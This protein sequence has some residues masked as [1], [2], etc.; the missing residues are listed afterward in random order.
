MRPRGSV[1]GNL[2]PPGSTF[3]RGIRS[4]RV[5]DAEEPLQLPS[6]A[7][8]TAHSKDDSDDDGE[9]QRRF[10]RAANRAGGGANPAVRGARMDDGS[11]LDPAYA[12]MVRANPLL[13]AD[14]EFAALHPEQIFG[15]YTSH[16]K[17]S[18]ERKE[19]RNQLMDIAALTRLA[20]DAV[21]RF[22]QRHRAL[23]AKTNPKFTAAQVESALLLELPHTPMGCLGA[24][25]AAAAADRGEGP[26]G[27]A[28]STT[29][30]PVLGI[31]LRK[32]PPPDPLP[33]VKAGVLQY[34]KRELDK[35]RDCRVSKTDFLMQ[36]KPTVAKLMKIDAPSKDI[37]V[38][39]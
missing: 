33:D 26:G 27:A 12:D 6:P 18:F 32:G 23:I 15:F 30:V 3:T 34:L 17:A 39:L 29:T 13:W 9:F 4:A 5:G 1:L 37:C 25:M 8:S 35:D 21:E 31:S 7:L 22:L 14:P 11:G 2:T 10:G 20:N 38:I 24:A 19:P 16:Q 28:G 36:W